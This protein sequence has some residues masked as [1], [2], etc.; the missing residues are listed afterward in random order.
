VARA[1]IVSQIT[2]VKNCARGIL[3]T[4]GHV[5]PKRLRATC[6]AS[7][8]EIIEGH[9]TLEP[10]LMPMLRTLAATMEQL[11]VYDRGINRFARHSETVRHLM[12][13]PSV[14]TVV[15]LTS[16]ASRRQPTSERIRLSLSIPSWHAI[17]Y[18]PGESKRR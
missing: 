6:I 3:K 14:G 17:P 4:F 10:I 11:Q 15:A 8:R 7:V 2:T 13:A 5:L 1:L 12:T 16:Q 18:R 9:A